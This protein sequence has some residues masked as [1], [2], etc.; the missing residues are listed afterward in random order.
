[1]S[2]DLIM[3]HCRCGQAGVCIV[4]ESGSVPQH[5]ERNTEGNGGPEPAQP[6]PHRQL[7]HPFSFNYQ[8]VQ[9]RV[10]G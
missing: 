6:F 3:S 2:D 7:P 1:M 5:G 8:R 10:R 4:Q 9:S